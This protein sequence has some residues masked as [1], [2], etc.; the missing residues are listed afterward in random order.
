MLVE[1]PDCNAFVEMKVIASYDYE[2]ED[3]DITG[4]YSFLKCPRCGRPLLILQTSDSWGWDSPT[5]IYPPLETGTSLEV[6]SSIRATYDEARTCFRARAFTATAIMCRK[7][8][9]GIC[10]E[11]KIAARSLALALGEMRDKGIIE[12][13][14]YEWADTLRITGNEAA[15]ET[16]ATISAEDARDILEFTHALLEYVFTFRDRFERF[17]KRRANNSKAT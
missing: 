12:S 15:H 14:L 7:T 4:R 3:V 11:H 13:R 1:C 6:P 5:R 9:E 16:N 8:L 10:E 2:E 17:K